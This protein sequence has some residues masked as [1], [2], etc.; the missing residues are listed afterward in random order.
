MFTYNKRDDMEVEAQPANDDRRVM[1]PKPISIYF[2]TDVENSKANE[3]LKH[4]ILVEF[5]V[6]WTKLNQSF[7]LL[8]LQHPEPETSR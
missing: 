1:M 8:F 2:N 3:D 6:E 5:L 4:N 7:Q